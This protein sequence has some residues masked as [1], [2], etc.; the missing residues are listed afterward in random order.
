[1]K[2][3]LFLFLVSSASGIIINCEFNNDNNW[4]VIGKVKTCHVTSADFSDNSTHITGVGRTHSSGKSNVYV[5][6]I[7]FGWP[8]DC[9][10]NLQKIPKGF[11]KYFPNLI[12]LSFKKCPI[13]T[14]NGDELD[15]YPNLQ[16]YAQQDS[17]LTR[18]PG[19][20][21]KSTPNMKLIYFGI[22]KI[23]NVGANLLDHLKDL[24]EV[25]FYK[26]SC[27]DKDALSSSQVPALIEELRQKCPDIEPEQII[28]FTTAISTTTQAPTTTSEPPTTTMKTFPLE[29]EQKIEKL[30]E[31]Q[32]KKFKALVEKLTETFEIFVKSEISNQISKI[33][34]KL[35]QQK[36]EIFTLASKLSTIEEKLPAIENQEN[37]E[38]FTEKLSGI[39]KSCENHKNSLRNHITIEYAKQMKNNEKS[40][41]IMASDL[42]GKIEK[43]CKKED[44][45]SEW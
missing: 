11:L 45:D 18:I 13:S 20:F 39:E 36:S 3:F 40:F 35:D 22:N 4:F 15:E 17:N 34:E 33:E 42:G 10:V 14:L 16:F 32:E 38:I 19:N 31:D 9:P 8:F 2:I 5:K 7:H 43:T 28:P 26:N 24:Q 30:F 27:I 41:G 12:G 44:F 25:Y 21:F 6:M 29:C 37:C 1:M 23:Q